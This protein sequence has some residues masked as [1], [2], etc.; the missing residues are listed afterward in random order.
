MVQQ[1]DEPNGVIRLSINSTTRQGRRWADGLT[2]D[3]LQDIKSACGYGD[4]DAVEVYPPRIDEVNVA[5]MRHLWILPVP[6][7]FVWRRPV[8]QTSNI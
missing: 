6:L 2:W 1:Y 7:S 3:T 4:R 5:N 8:S